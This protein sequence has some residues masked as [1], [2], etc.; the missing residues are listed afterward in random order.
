MSQTKPDQN[1]QGYKIEVI[2][3]LYSGFSVLV[4]CDIIV[5]D[6]LKFKASGKDDGHEPP[7]RY[8]CTGIGPVSHIFADG[9]FSSYYWINLLGADPNTVPI[10]KSITIHVNISP[11][12]W[13]SQV[14]KIRPDMVKSHTK[15]GIALD[16]G[17]V[18]W[19]VA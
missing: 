3:E 2:G 5:D 10:P 15:K 13:K 6:G 9:S 8:G 12:V 14:L 7:K 4:G 16:L 11:D 19:I 17:R 18:Q 1:D